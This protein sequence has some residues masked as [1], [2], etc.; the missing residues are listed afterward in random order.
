MLAFL[1]TNTKDLTAV[2]RPCGCPLGP[3]GTECQQLDNHLSLQPNKASSMHG[4]MGYDRH[5]RP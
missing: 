2:R 5:H 1:D 4:D 3:P